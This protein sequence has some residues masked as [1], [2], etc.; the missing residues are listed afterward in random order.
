MYVIT[1]FTKNKKEID[2]HFFLFL[3]CSFT[4]IICV[5]AEK[6][7]DKDTVGLSKVTVGLKKWPCMFTDSLSWPVFGTTAWFPDA[8]IYIIQQIKGEQSVV[9]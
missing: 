8:Q 6:I 4:F 5:G 2:H 3:H 7:K 1:Y 9:L